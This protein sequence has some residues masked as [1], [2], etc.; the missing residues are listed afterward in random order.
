VGDAHVLIDDTPVPGALGRAVPI[1]PGP[2]V[3]R[4]EQGRAIARQSFVAAEGEKERAIA[5][6]LEPEASAARDVTSAQASAP[7]PIPWTV[8]ALGGL[9]AIGIG[10]FIYLAA[11]GQSTYDAC[12]QKGCG[13]DRQESLRRERF[14]AWSMLGVGLVA[15][16]AAIWIFADSPKATWKVGVT[17]F[18]GGPVIG[19]T[20]SF[21]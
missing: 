14:V 7:A 8:Y 11:D 5:I 10:A 18:N 15:S 3:V 19:A 12:K 9:G 4:I 16:T 17:S 2:H 20:G 6:E 1:D 21:E 13:E